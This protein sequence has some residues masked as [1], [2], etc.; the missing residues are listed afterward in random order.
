MIASD[1]RAATMENQQGRHGRHSVDDLK[2]MYGRWGAALFVGS[3]IVGSIS[4]LVQQAAGLD[5][6]P[7]WLVNVVSTTIGVG[8]WFLPWSR[9]PI[10]AG[11]L[12]A[13]P[14]FALIALYNVL[15]G[16]PGQF[17]IFFIVIFAWIGL[18]QPRWTSLKF[19]PLAVVA[20]VLPYIIAGQYDVDAA[21]ET[22]YVVAASVL[23]GE[24]LS[25]VSHRLVATREALD[26]E[27]AFRPLVQNASDVIVAI[28]R[29]GVIRYISPSIS[30]LTGRTPEQLSGVD[31]YTHVHPEDQERL[32]KAFEA[33]AV[34]R[35][36]APPLE[37]R[38]RHADGSWRWIEARVNN[39]LFDPTVG[40][41][42]NIFTGD[43]RLMIVHEVENPA[44]TPLLGRSVA[45]IARER[46]RDDVD[47]FLDLVLEDNLGMQ[48][49]YELF[50]SDESRTPDL[51][52][53]PR[54]MIGFSDGGAHVDMFCDAGYATYLLGTW[55]R[56]KQALTL[57]HAVKRMTTEPAAFF[58]ITERG[59][60]A[61]GMAADFAI[62]DLSRVGSKKRGEMAHDLPGG[63]RRLVVPATGIEYTIV[64]GSVLFEHGK[65]SGARV[66]Q[67]LRSGRC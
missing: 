15:I 33:A 4:A 2:G 49:T 55:V 14:A 12:F 62:F 51:I 28:D 60:I 17:A 65:D 57:E 6:T 10:W 67:V 13:P 23:V 66:G 61:P 25:W 31:I 46:G 3:G 26:E 30:L 20:H 21:V 35:G 38:Y 50:N 43:W 44:L 7:A 48:F 18:A 8:A 40:A 9:W 1:A 39:L 5:A 11:L 42:C 47:T 27:A 19:A 16:D 63:G 58:G 24:T 41:C 37:L 64:N 32:R 34:A 29:F 45:D 54:T 53:D 59:R 22:L 56:D 52:C 36:V